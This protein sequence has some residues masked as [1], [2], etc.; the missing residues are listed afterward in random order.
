MNRYHNTVYDI[1]W[2]L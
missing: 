1:T 2:N